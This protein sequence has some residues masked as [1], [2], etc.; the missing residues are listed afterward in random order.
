M[1]HTWHALSN[2]KCTD[3][4]EERG[5]GRDEEECVKKAEMTSRLMD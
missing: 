4:A 3:Q 2:G 5:I 1:K